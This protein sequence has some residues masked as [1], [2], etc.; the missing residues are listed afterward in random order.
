MSARISDLF[1]AISFTNTYC[2]SS[3]NVL[4]YYLW[5]MRNALCTISSSSSHLA[6]Y[7][8]FFTLFPSFLILI[9][10]RIDNKTELIIWFYYYSYR[11]CFND[12][13]LWTTTHQYLPKYIKSPALFRLSPALFSQKPRKSTDIWKKKKKKR[14]FL[15]FSNFGGFLAV[16]G[17]LIL[18]LV[19]NFYFIHLR[20]IS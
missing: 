8:L 13:K 17:P 9:D 2:H 6:H 19:F 10:F 4:Y 18:F 20:C 3:E 15:I 5:I 16:F 7:N 14:S 11:L 12:E 1:S